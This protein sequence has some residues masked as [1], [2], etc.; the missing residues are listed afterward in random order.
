[1][2]DKTRSRP[3]TVNNLSVDISIDGIIGYFER[4]QYVDE[5]LQK[6]G[7]SVEHLGKLLEDDEIG[8]VDTICIGKRNE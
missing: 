5:V 1:M 3:A 8:I 6:A 7:L 4:Y 2:S